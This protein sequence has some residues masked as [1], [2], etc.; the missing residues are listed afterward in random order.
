VAKHGPSDGLACCF[1]FSLGFPYSRLN[2]YSTE[3]FEEPV[4][5]W[6]FEERRDCADQ[7]TNGLEKILV[8]AVSY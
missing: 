2:P 4:T 5:S 1:R 3:C 7:A 8:S 6:T